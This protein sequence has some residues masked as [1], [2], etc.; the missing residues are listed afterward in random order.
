MGGRQRFEMAGTAGCLLLTERSIW[1]LRKGKA[2]LASSGA[3]SMSPS[4][5]P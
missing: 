4:R 1:G 3:L 5:A 2:N